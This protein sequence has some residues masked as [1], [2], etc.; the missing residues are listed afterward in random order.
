[1][2]LEMT[3]SATADDPETALTQ[4]QHLRALGVE[5]S[6]DDFG[7]GYSSLSYLRRYPVQH[8]KVDRSFIAEVDTNPEDH[9]IVSSVIN[10]A[11]SLG[12]LVVGEG[13]ETADQLHALR[14]MGC[15]LGQGYLWRVPAAADDV[16]EW[17]RTLRA[18]RSVGATGPLA[19]EP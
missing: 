11:H 16:S 1:L 8:L 12:L 15:D 10:L 6:I 4:L 7:T 19:V 2:V 5:L 14:G 9:A 17:L 13:V 18:G 3:E